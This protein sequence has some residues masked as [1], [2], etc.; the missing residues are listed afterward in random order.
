VVPFFLAK[1]RLAASNRLV[2]V[3]ATHLSLA[4]T[5]QHARSQ[6]KEMFL[7][8]S[9]RKAG[10]RVPEPRFRVGVLLEAVMQRELDLPLL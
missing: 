7:V 4:G 5:Q 3:K 10:L 2:D 9:N 8:S 6:A 1:P